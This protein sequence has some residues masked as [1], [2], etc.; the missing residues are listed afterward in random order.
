MKSMRDLGAWSV[1]D[2]KVKEIDGKS[3]LPNRSIVR[4]LFRTD[5]KILK[6]EK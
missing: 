5:L 4:S 1:S 6:D 3:V 2:N